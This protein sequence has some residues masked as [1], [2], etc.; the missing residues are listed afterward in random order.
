MR[1]LITGSTGLVGRN[2]LEHPKIAEH[3]LFTPSR[4][5]LDLSDGAKVEDYMAKVKP[6]LVIHAAG[7][8]GGIQANIE[9]PVDFLVDNLE[10]GKNVVLGAKRTGVKKLIN[11]GSSC[12]YPREGKNPLL[13]DIILTG[14]LEPTNEGYALAKITIAKLCEYISKENSGYKYITLIPCNLY[15][16]WDKFDPTHSHLIPAIVY[17]LH[18]AMAEGIEEVE[19]WGDGSARR[20][21]MYTADLADCIARAIT[22][23]DTVPLLMNAGLGVDYSINEYYQSV[24]HVIGF[25]GKFIYDLSKPV[26][27]KQKVVDIQRLDAWGWRARTSLSEGIAG[28]YAFYVNHL[29]QDTLKSKRRKQ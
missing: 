21:F 14:A 15:G 23:F 1:L 19:V 18:R 26:G 20:E 6:D 4:L 27:M 16:R 25:K 5:D 8:V 13:E 22:N 11:L 10:M 29:C 28:T 24:A 12:M 3:T 2:I 9:C 17:K 7:M